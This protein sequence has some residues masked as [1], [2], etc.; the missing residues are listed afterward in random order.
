M[1]SV[2]SQ[3]SFLFAALIFVLGPTTLF[4]QT[5][6]RTSNE[7]ILERYLDQTS[8]VTADDAVRI[9]LENNGELLA[10]QSDVDAARAL[11]KQ[12]RLRANPSL[13]TSGSRQVAG[14]DN[15]LMVRGM[16]PLELGGRRAA[17]IL[18]AER[19]AS[20]R[21]LELAD[22]QRL[23]ASEVRMKFGDALARS[24]KLQLAE[25]LVAE[26]V[27]QLDLV[28]ARVVEG[29]TAPL[30][31]SMMLV[32]V[33]RLR[34]VREIAEGETNIVFLELRSLMNMRPEDPLRIRGDFQNLLLTLP[35]IGD[36]VT[37]A[38]QNRPD[39]AGM[40]AIEDLSDA[41]IEQAR[42]KGRID[43]SV[44]GGYERMN[45]SFPLN[46]ISDAGQLRPIQGIF[47]S[48]VFGVTLQLPV[49]DRNQGAIEA[50]AAYRDAA[51]RRR[52]FAEIIIR[53]EVAAARARYESS[54]R[55]LEIYRVGVL[56]RSRTN[57]DVV[58]QTYELGSK[59][60]LD[61]IAER[62]RYIETENEFIDQQRDVY[63]A[64]IE[65]LRATAA[66]ELT[67]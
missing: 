53:R 31:E 26:A 1:Q 62:R 58:R 50:A 67:Q 55:G 30:E 46:G 42:A 34:S 4:S 12:A 39:L 32:E 25:N 47:H 56:D 21:E 63:Q 11:V 49:R 52:E 24:L 7:I 16:L 48:L 51:Q 13:E 14:T 18:V 29:R 64:R 15:T 17:R 33:N 22:R 9:A 59:S 19:E 38:L 27:Q 65:I 3:I 5:G 43:A 61:Y 20:L 10:L 54:A 6:T 2:F 8:G 41:R 40:R 66:P 57:L 28:K 44:N 45:F 36:A 60:L 35:P 23:L 37:A